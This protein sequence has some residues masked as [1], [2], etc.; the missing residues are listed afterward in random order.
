M[1]LVSTAAA[2]V[3]D[4]IL[5]D[6]GWKHVKG[7]G[8][9]TVIETMT[10]YDYDSIVYVYGKRHWTT[11]CNDWTVHI[12]QRETSTFVDSNHGNWQ[13]TYDRGLTPLNGSTAFITGHTYIN[14]PHYTSYTANPTRSEKG[15]TLGYDLMKGNTLKFQA[16]SAASTSDGIEYR[17]VVV[18]SDGLEMIN[19]R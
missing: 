5:Y 16:D 12:N 18:R 10:G 14:A 1:A 6:S 13:S 4:P 8:S 7:T 11:L 9:A 2:T 19:K 15:G 17:I 3:V